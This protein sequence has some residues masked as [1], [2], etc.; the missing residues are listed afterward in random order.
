MGSYG[1]L[2][3]LLRCTRVIMLYRF[4]NWSGLHTEQRVGNG[5]WSLF[6]A[7]HGMLSWRQVGRV[8]CREPH[9]QQKEFT[10]LV[11]FRHTWAGFLNTERQCFCHYSRITSCV[12]LNRSLEQKTMQRVYAEKVVARLH[13]YEQ[14]RDCQTSRPHRIKGRLDCFYIFSVFFS[15]RSALSVS[16]I[17]PWRSAMVQ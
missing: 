17:M 9:G 3:S 16:S 7:L 5:K 14:E 10:C 12:K 11:R 6:G 15:R 4:D 2:G 13:Y 1:R 8:V